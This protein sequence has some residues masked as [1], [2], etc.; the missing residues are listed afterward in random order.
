MIRRRGPEEEEIS[1]SDEEDAFAALS[2]NTEAK[3]SRVDST[4][5]VS[6]PDY[7]RKTSFG[8]T[9]STE[10]RTL[11][12]KKPADLASCMAT[13][14]CHLKLPLSVT[15][16]M[17][18]HHKPSDTR[19]AKMEALLMELEVEKGKQKNRDPRPFEHEKKGSFV[20]PGEEKLTSNL[21]VGNLAP[22]ITEEDLSNLFSQFGDLYSLKIM[23]PRTM[24]ERQRG[25]N[26]GF[27]CFMNREDAE[28]ALESCNDTDPFNVGRLLAMGWGKNVKKNVRRGTGGLVESFTPREFGGPNE[29][30]STNR[31]G[32]HNHL[33]TEGNDERMRPD[34]FPSFILL[35]NHIY[36]RSIPDPYDPKL[37]SSGSIRIEAP[38]DPDRF[39]FISLVA[40]YVA[41]D[42]VAVEKRLR[43]E[44]E[45][46][47]LFKFLS[48][49]NADER[50]RK[51]YLF[52]RWRVYA[53]AQGDAFFSWRTDPFVMFHPN[54]RYWI[55]PPLINNATDHER[56]LIGEGQQRQRHDFQPRTKTR[57]MATGR[58]IERARMFRRKGLGLHRENPSNLDPKEQI[59]FDLLVRKNLT[60]SR[61]R[62]CRAMAFC[63]DKCLA[64]KQISGL[65]RDALLDESTSVTIDMRIARLF[66][67]SDVLFNSQQPG[68]RNAFMYRTTIESMAPDIFSGLGKYRESSIGRMTVNKLRRAVSAVLGA[69]T[70]W[71][72]YNAAFMDELEAH[73]EGREIERHSMVNANA[74]HEEE[75]EEDRKIEGKT[76]NGS[77]TSDCDAG[78]IKEAFGSSMTSDSNNKIGDEHT[79]GE[80]VPSRGYAK[81][82]VSVLVRDSTEDLD[83][84]PIGSDV[85]DID[86]EEV[87]S[88]D[89][90]GEEF[91]DDEFQAP[92]ED[93]ND[94]QDD[95]E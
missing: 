20:E 82:L 28:E 19:K 57:Q 83:G 21:F 4:N 65:L 94:V 43:S 56:D 12:S 69:W 46:N 8:T 72:V 88:E 93:G 80:N 1:S 36:D 39:Q 62:I 22:S 76:N 54:G 32:N 40:L 31:D 78:F 16:S 35:G 26:T 59:E 24:E 58:Q 42:G 15:S 77:R 48:L 18:R 29:S 91:D 7:G 86:G 63:F 30:K 53:F 66:L 14:P 44:E 5:D 34:G 3:R 17:K 84:E 9:D 2:R 70:D 38:T 41:K 73:F 23:W 37:H 85:E 92:F 90:D 71:G 10:I 49:D 50:Q 51:E 68:I 74:C 13:E 45:G 67:L 47:S 64:A 52:Y 33:R 55:P 75:E 11:P 25:R 89:I 95:V 79:V 61:E 27:V 60:L 81:P 87:H 6:V